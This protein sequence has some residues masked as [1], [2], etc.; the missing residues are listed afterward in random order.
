MCA[1]LPLFLLSS[2]FG[3]SLWGQSRE[4]ILQSLERRDYSFLDG[5][6]PGD[7]GKIL[8][9]GSEAPYFVGL[10]LVRGGKTEEARR[11]FGVGS[12]KSPEPYKSLC[13][14]E[15]TKLGTAT[16]RLDA[17][18][19]ILGKNGDDAAARGLKDDLLLESGDFG[20]IT[21]GVSTLYYSRPMNETL[22]TAFSGLPAD[23]P[24][25]FGD[26][27]AARVEVFRKSYQSAWVK[28][29]ALLGSGERDV[30]RRIV[31]SDFGK[32]ALYGSTEGL[33]DAKFLDDLYEKTADAEARYVLAFYAGRMYAR[34]ATGALPFGASSKGMM[35]AKL[36]KKARERFETAIGLAPNADDY[37][38]AL[39]YLLDFSIVTESGDTV[40]LIS[41]YAPK[42]GVPDDFSDILDRV[43]VACVQKRDWKTL[44]A[45][46]AALPESTDSDTMTRLDYLAARS[47]LLS[48]EETKASCSRA[49]ADDRGSLYYR[50]MAA[51]VL[52]IPIG[53]PAPVS[54]PSG[55]APSDPREFASE[56][57]MRVLRGYLAWFLPERVY[58]SVSRFYPDLPLSFAR[59]L[60]AG[61]EKAGRRGDS[62][63]VLIYAMH[64]GSEPVTDAD[65][66]AIYP[67]PW[68]PEVSA[69]A[70]R[71]GVPEYLLYALM[72]SES[73][74]QD[75]A[76][77]RAGA[78]GLTQLMKPTAADIARKLSAESFDLLDPATNI[79]F[80]AYYLSE[81]IR[82]LDGHTMPALFAYNAGITKV[83]SWQKAAAGLPGDLFLESLPYAE[84]REYGRKVLAAAA[85]YGYLYYGKNTD[86]IARDLF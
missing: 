34:L 6:E 37:D 53:S 27:T 86:E 63:R 7:Y 73:L 80:G 77:S 10:N 13:L 4:E 25:P 29:R 49:F 31:L 12:E 43:I 57:A 33:A 70:E 74:F 5:V 54:R 79:T 14:E 16:E 26:I 17:V 69:A 85:V 66:A 35:P 36:E 55:S 58:P 67:R 81:L 60:S 9:L 23:I 75:D 45:L 50:T 84:T 71:F 68:L 47:G 1:F 72:R 22:A 65:L 62:L 76:L 28:A 59:E 64:N 32:A 15:L 52:G 11:M 24:A 83:R 39:W 38:N 40:A 41:R 82:R 19:R 2:C 56:A 48:P 44:V 78:I 21:G 51:S 61:L 20:R 3:F 46:R 30:F 8:S 18:G 42:W